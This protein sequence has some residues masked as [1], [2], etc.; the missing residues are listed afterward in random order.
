M[1]RQEDRTIK[2][3]WY[4]KSIASGRFLNFHSGHPMSLKMNTAFNFAKRVMLFSTNL[5]PKDI[6][7]T[8]FSQLQLNDYPPNIINR[9]INRISGMRQRET[10]ME[11]SSNVNNEG[12]TTAYCSLT[13]IKGLTKT[14]TKTLR[15]DYPNIRIA[16]KQHKNIG[17]LLPLVKDPTPIEER[18]NVIYRIDCA[19]C[20]ACYVG[21]TTQKLKARV[22]K[23]KSNMK[24]LQTLQRA[25]HT[26]RDVA[27]QSIWDTTALVNHAARTEHSFKLEETKIIDS[28]YKSRNLPILESCRIHNTQNTVNKRTDTDNLHVAYAGVLHWMKNNVNIPNRQ[29]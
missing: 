9:T 23:H 25:G 29:N 26:T 28:T 2:T 7:K 19:D 17:K 5:G 15:R 18:S 27:I 14:I 21:M 8:I 22:S 3:E 11:L 12:T 1:V 4:T 13:N 20:N 16:N 24:K 10:A 6:R